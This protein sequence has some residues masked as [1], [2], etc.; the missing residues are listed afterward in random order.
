MEFGLLGVEEDDDHSGVGFV[1][2]SKLVLVQ[3]VA[4]Y[5]RGHLTEF[6]NDK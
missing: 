5:G 3:G 4:S 2:I 6:G 1:K